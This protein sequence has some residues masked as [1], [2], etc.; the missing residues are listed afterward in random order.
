MANFCGS[1]LPG[2]PNFSMYV[3]DILSPVEIVEEGEQ[4]E[5]ELDPALALALVQRVRVHDRRRVVQAGA[6]HHRPVEVS[7]N[8]DPHKK[9]QPLKRQVLKI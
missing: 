7:E 3:W 5:S 4:V 2:Y 9:R 1:R 8:K 6:A